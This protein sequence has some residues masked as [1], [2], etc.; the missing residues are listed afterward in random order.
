MSESTF[1]FNS[2]HPEYVAHV[3]AWRRARDAYSGGTEYIRQ[4][5]I[6][7]VSEFPLEF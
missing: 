1:I 6:R 5:L 3:E 7:H 2:R 4:A